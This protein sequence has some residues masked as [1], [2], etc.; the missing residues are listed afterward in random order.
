M[1]YL[2]SAL[3][4]S[5]ITWFRYQYP[6]HTIFAIP[7]G[8][9]RNIREAVR[10]KVE[11]TLAGV[12]D[13]FLMAA[14]KNYNGLFIEMKIGKGKQSDAQIEFELKAKHQNYQYIVCRTFDQFKTE[15]EYYLNN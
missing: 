3:Q 6:K 12:A 4:K 8:G 15:I 2:E 11:G 10:L 5:C 7:N 1:K 9:A 13:L 14:N